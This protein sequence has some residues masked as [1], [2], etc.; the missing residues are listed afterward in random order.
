MEKE[1][2]AIVWATKYFRPYLFGRS[3]K[4]CSDHKLLVWLHNIKEPNM[5]LQ[6]WNI[7]LREFDCEIMFIKGKENHVA[8]ALYRITKK[9][10]KITKLKKYFKMKKFRYYSRYVYVFNH[11]LLLDKGNQDTNE[12]TH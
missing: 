6:R 3:F 8:Y 5:I 4:K 9:N 12:H 2:L 1:I 10:E 7:K 11:Q